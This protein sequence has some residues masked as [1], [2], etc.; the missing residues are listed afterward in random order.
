MKTVALYGGS[1]DPPHVGHE[2]IVKAL[3][4]LKFIDEIVIMPTYLNPFKSEYFAPSE[5]R[6]E[7]L[8]EIFVE[9]EK[10]FVSDYEVLQKEQVPSIKTVKY[11]LKSYKKIFLVVGADNLAT[12]HKWKDYKELEQRVTF[13]I[14]T[15]DNHKVP[16]DF[17]RII[18]DQEISSSELR[19][20]VD[21]TKLPKKCAKLIAQHYKETH[22]K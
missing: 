16:S 6:L 8:K 14:A 21:I 1:F 22:A 12:L 7:W 9:Y 19:E 3:V 2:A 11:L 17:M 10:T 13:I 20:N 18:I 5:L 15:R 4:R